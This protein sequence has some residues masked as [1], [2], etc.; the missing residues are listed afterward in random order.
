MIIQLFC[1]IGVQFVIFNRENDNIGTVLEGNDG[2]LDVGQKC[3][4]IN[5]GPRRGIYY[6]F[7]FVL[8]I[9]FFFKLQ[10]IFVEIY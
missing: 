2:F 5:P 8:S 3:F 7:V 1:E 4:R 6:R 10:H 9:N